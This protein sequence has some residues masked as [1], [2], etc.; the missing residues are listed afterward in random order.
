MKIDVLQMD[1]VTHHLRFGIGP[2]TGSFCSA[3]VRYSIKRRTN[4]FLAPAGERGGFVFSLACFLEKGPALSNTRQGRECLSISR[5]SATVRLCRRKIALPRYQFGLNLSAFHPDIY[6]ASGCLGRRS[7]VHSR[8]NTAS[9]GQS[10]SFMKHGLFRWRDALIPKRH[11]LWHVQQASY[12]E[13]YQLKVTFRRNAKPARKLFRYI[14]FYA[15][16]RF[17]DSDPA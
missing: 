2:W 8:K 12:V 7:P 15:G 4:P 16:S 11:R 10:G 3:L 1:S 13:R 5:R 14:C 6:V 17:T 9:A